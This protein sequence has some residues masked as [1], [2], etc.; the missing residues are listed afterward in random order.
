MAT[1][2]LSGHIFKSQKMKI[3]ALKLQRKTDK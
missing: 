1:L 3:Y 2:T